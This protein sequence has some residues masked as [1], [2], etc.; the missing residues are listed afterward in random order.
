MFVSCFKSDGGTIGLGTGRSELIYRRLRASF[1]PSPRAMLLSLTG[2][3]GTEGHLLHRQLGR[4]C[5]AL[6][7]ANCPKSLHC[8]HTAFAERTGGPLP[9]HFAR[10]IISHHALELPRLLAHLLDS[11]SMVFL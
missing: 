9:V 1:V 11:L 3:H 5:V 6:G 8:F 2:R 4:S 7:V 10:Q